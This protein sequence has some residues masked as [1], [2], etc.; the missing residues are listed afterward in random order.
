MG[1]SHCMMINKIYYLL[2]KLLVLLSL[3]AGDIYSNIYKF[4]F[5]MTK[6]TNKLRIK[7]VKSTLCTECTIFYLLSP[8][9]IK[10]MYK[11]RTEEVRKLRKGKM[12]KG[13]MI[14]IKKEKRKK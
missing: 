7:T 9:W 4:I 10:K 2:H 14:N 1:G 13:N 5:S 11:T 8:K 6:Y 3:A 12:E